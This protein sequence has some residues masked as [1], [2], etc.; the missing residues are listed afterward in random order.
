MEN[1]KNDEGNGVYEVKLEYRVNTTPN[2][3]FQRLFTPYGLSEWFADD[4]NLLGNTYTF[5]WNGSTRKAELVEK[6]ENKY[7]KFR[8][9]EAE[10]NFKTNY[11]FT[12]QLNRDDITNELSL[13]VT[14][15]I[16]DLEERDEIISLWNYQINELK[17]AIG[18]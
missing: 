8:W 9:I 11:H 7:I 6:K 18:A 3:L 2:I 14:E 16:E 1:M 5:I 4:V 12:F 17:K 13:L 15:E 10:G